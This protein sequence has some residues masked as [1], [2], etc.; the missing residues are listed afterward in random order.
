MS[1]RTPKTHID[2]SEPMANDSEDTFEGRGQSE[3][4]EHDLLNDLLP[5][6]KAA[7]QPPSCSPAPTP[8]EQEEMR[9]RWQWTVGRNKAFAELAAKASVPKPKHSKT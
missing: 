4:D 9:A 2:N 3:Q 1:K 5:S 8:E 6:E 7:T